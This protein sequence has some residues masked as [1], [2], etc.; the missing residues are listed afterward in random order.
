MFISSFHCSITTAP[1]T[2]Q[3][4][5]SLW[6]LPSLSLK[7]GRRG[8]ILQRVKRTK[9]VAASDGCCC[10]CWIVEAALEKAHMLHRHT[11]RPTRQTNWYNRYIQGGNRLYCC[12]LLSN[13]S[14]HPIALCNVLYSKERERMFQSRAGS[15]FSLNRC[16]VLLTSGLVL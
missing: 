1:S 2:P 16:V 10:L 12:I 13:Y 15:I 3:E 9:D 7:R 5:W 4:S 8:L 14:M 11:Y 6:M